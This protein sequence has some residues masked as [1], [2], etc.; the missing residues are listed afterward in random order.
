[1]T[2]AEKSDNVRAVGRALEILLAFTEE[3]PELSAGELLKRVDLSR[4]TLYRLLYTLQEHSFLVSV[5]E[6]QRF[7]LGPAV[8]RLAH[9]WKSTLDLSALAEPVLRRIWQETKETVALFV[10]QGNMRLCVAELPSPQPLN[11]KRGV[12][13]T[14]RV[15]LGAT[16]RAILAYMEPTPEQLRSYVQGTSVDPKELEAELA[17]TRKRGYSNSRSEL[18][19]GAVAVAAPFFDRHGQ[20]AGSI[21]VFG[22]EVRLDGARQ[23]EVA[24]LLLEGAVRLS[25]ALGFGTAARAVA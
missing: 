6:P 13:Y 23:K 21:G 2:I 4:P 15:V 14:E 22:P 12:G 16:G 9:V 25:E 10:P 1:M 20:V 7:R 11:F 18:I 19:S 17:A 5:G 8:A 3:D 24:N